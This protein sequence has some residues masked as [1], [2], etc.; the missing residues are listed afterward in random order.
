MGGWK[1][2]LGLPVT[3]LLGKLTVYF[4]AVLICTSLHL[5]EVESVKGW[6]RD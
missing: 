3:S 2:A 4:D 5:C 6:S 1:E